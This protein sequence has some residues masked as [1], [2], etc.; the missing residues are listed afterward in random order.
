MIET[1]EKAQTASP[2]YVLRTKPQS[3]RIV[4]SGLERDG[5]E[6]FLPAVRTMRSRTGY[7]DE[8]LFPGYVFL[9]Y[10]RENWDWFLVNRLPGIQ[11]WVRFNGTASSVPDEIVKELAQRVEK[12]NKSGG[13]WTRFRRGQKV[14]V[15]SEGL[16][17]LAEVIEEPKTPKARVDVLL[18]F[19]GRMVTARV[20]WHNLRPTE[21]S[22]GN[23][24]RKLPRRTRG[25]G[26]WIRGF[27]PHTSGPS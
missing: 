13:L 24:G 20:P 22:S 10:D 3:E 5:F 23:Q 25:R 4:A 12:I 19:M 7:S 1:P 14:R 27:G 8:P 6:V 18:E 21:E 2:W 9:R 16:D 15:V 26:R 17:S 11:G